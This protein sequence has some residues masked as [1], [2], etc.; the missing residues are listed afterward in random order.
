MAID[1]SRETDGLMTLPPEISN[2]IWANTRV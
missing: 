2:E 1:I